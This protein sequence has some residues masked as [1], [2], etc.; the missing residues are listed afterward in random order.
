MKIGCSSLKGITMRDAD[1]L[2]MFDVCFRKIKPC[3]DLIE[4][5][6]LC[7]CEVCFELSYAGDNV[8]VR[9]WGR[10]DVN[11]QESHFIMESK[12]LNSEN[13]FLAF[14]NLTRALKRKRVDVV[15]FDLKWYFARY[16]IHKV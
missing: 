6:D 12:P 15:L 8:V 9:L 5:D 13:V 10:N 7:K 16:F 3:I 14:K 2:S 4:N 1:L 11:K